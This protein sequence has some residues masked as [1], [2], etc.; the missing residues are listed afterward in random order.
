MRSID[1]LNHFVR[2]TVG[3]LTT[4]VSISSVIGEIDGGST[5]IHTMKVV[6]FE[7]VI[8]AVTLIINLVSLAR[9]HI[10]CILGIQHNWKS[11]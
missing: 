2:R 8:I 4:H 3:Y 1:L 10:G 6:L 9:N 7:A 5:P 11:G